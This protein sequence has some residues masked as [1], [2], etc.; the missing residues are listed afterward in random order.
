MSTWTTILSIILLLIFLISGVII[1]SSSL[2]LYTTKDTDSYFA[3][4]YY[5]STWASVVTWVLVALAIIAVGVYMYFYFQEAPKLTLISSY[6]QPTSWSILFL[7]IMLILV[8]IIGILAAYTTYNIDQSKNYNPNVPSQYRAREEAL[9]TA[10]LCLVSAGLLLVWGIVELFYY[11]NPEIPE[12]IEVKEEI[13]DIKN[14][15]DKDIKNITNDVKTETIK[16][17]I[18]NMTPEQI[19]VLKQLLK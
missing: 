6:T 12:K 19:E 8:I 4:A 9:V 17:N 2:N 15:T 1:T 16:T 10:I 11:F 13:K 7:I 18:T 14:V 3:N 5:Y